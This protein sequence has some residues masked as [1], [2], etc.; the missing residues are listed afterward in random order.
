MC[1]CLQHLLTCCRFEFL[2]GLI[3]SAFGK[4]IATKLTDDA[5]DACNMLMNQVGW[6]GGGSVN[7]SFC[8]MLGL[9]GDVQDLKPAAAGIPPATCMYLY[10]LTCRSYCL[11]CPLRL[12]W[13]QTCSGVGARLASQPGAS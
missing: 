2:E 4:F 10:L 3:R 13:T 5:S 12:V 8:Y 9:E 6:V 1:V 11:P 7:D